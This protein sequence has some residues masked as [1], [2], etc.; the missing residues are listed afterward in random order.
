MKGIAGSRRGANGHEVVSMTVGEADSGGDADV[1]YVLT[2]FVGS[3]PTGWQ[4]SFEKLKTPL[5]LD[6]SGVS[7]YALPVYALIKVLC[8]QLKNFILPQHPCPW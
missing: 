1:S 7:V 3:S 6:P 8:F 5:G 4:C 2:S